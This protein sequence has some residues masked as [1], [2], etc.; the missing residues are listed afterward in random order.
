MKNKIL[1]MIFILIAAYQPSYAKQPVTHT[2]NGRT[3]THLLPQTGLNHSHNP[4]SKANPTIVKKR[5]KTKTKTR[6][7]AKVRRQANPSDKNIQ[8]KKPRV[9]V[10]RTPRIN[11]LS[12][13]STDC[14]VTATLISDTNFTSMTT[15]RGGSAD[16]FDAY[17]VYV[18]R[19]YILNA[20]TKKPYVTLNLNPSIRRKN[21]TDHRIGKK[22]SR[23][24]HTFSNILDGHSYIV[25]LGGAWITQ[26]RSVTFRC[27]NA[28]GQR[29][30]SLKTIKHI[31][32]MGDG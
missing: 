15:D 1:F 28:K 14:V 11:P 27:P 23:F 20:A 8:N 29:K 17:Y 32:I 12:G 10:K 25:T 3:H 22:Y 2:H 24:S 7:T 5:P 21:V 4:S 30:F 31:G 19:M 6:K 9:S 18:E 13:S 26:P 16:H